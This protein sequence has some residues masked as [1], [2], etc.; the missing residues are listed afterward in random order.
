MLS[1]WISFFIYA[2]VFFLNVTSL[3][4]EH[5]MCGNHPL[6]QM[7]EDFSRREDRSHLYHEGTTSL[8]SIALIF[9]RMHI[10]SESLICR[11]VD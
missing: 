2:I 9:S 7:L 6:N 10:T 8:P 4:D 5:F 3:V 1:K 11:N